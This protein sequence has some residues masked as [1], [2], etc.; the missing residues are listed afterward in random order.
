M[1]RG[2]LMLR[3]ARA[4]VE[5]PYA[6]VR[7]AVRHGARPPRLPPLPR[8]APPAPAGAGAASPVAPDP[9]RGGAGED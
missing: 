6:P 3:A 1:S 5:L 4:G 2:G 8:S 7:G 9:G